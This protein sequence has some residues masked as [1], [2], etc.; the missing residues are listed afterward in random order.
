MESF[1]PFGGGSA[2][3][4]VARLWEDPNQG[5]AMLCVE[6][7][8][9]ITTYGDNNC[10]TM[11]EIPDLTQIPK[12]TGGDWN[13]VASHACNDRVEGSDYMGVKYFRNINFI[14]GRKDCY[15]WHVIYD[16]PTDDDCNNLGKV[17][18]CRPFGKYLAN[19]ISGVRLKAVWED[20]A[21]DFDD[22]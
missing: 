7:E 12:S 5:G 2:R 14:R 15:N 4:P 11:A 20:C 10:Y 9:E 1:T 21:F 16:I 18:W 3:E 6:C 19:R 17:R 13:D 22:F 8:A